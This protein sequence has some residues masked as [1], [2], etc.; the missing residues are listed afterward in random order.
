MGFR[1]RRR[2]RGDKGGFQGGGGQGQG[3]AFTGEANGLQP[4]DDVGNRK[5]FKPV[6]VPPEDI[7]NRR[8]PDEEDDVPYDDVGNR[9][10]ANPTHEVSGILLDMD[11]KK[12]KRRAKGTQTITER[13]G[14]YIVG[15]VNPLIAGGNRPPPPPP[16]DDGADVHAFE[17]GDRP[18]RGDRGERPERG[19]RPDRGERGERPDRSDRKRRF[20]QVDGHAAQQVSERRAQRFFDFEEDDRFEYSL[21][22]TPEQ[23]RAEAL[24]FVDD[25]VR[26]SGRQAVV[27]ARVIEDGDKPK[28]LVTIDERGPHA[29]LSA[30]RITEGANDPLFVMG[31]AALMSLNYLANKV[32]NRYPDDRIR[33]AVLPAS[34]E[35]LYLESLALHQQKARS[36]PAP[37]LADGVAK[38]GEG[39]AEAVVEAV[40]DGVAAAAVAADEAVAAA[41]PAKKSRRKK[42]DVDA[43]DVA[44]DDVVAAVVAAVAA[45]EADVIA[46]VADVGAVDAPAK[47]APRSAPQPAQPRPAQAT[48]PAM[49]PARPKGGAKGRKKKSEEIIPSPMAY[50]P[51]P[52]PEAAPE[53]PKPGRRRAPLDDMPTRDQGRD[54]P[55]GDGPDRGPPRRP[56]RGPSLVEV[57]RVTKKT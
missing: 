8:D 20:E 6:I 40:V 42:A 31:N 4:G 21:K 29:K 30:E 23:K 11:P 14:R 26:E 55:R 45:V 34:D 1:S 38:V 5:S 48:L 35:P 13:V 25:V 33:L 43:A 36:A 3:Y 27:Q 24:R 12:R 49:E 52:E 28:L 2:H 57:V 41:P 53:A 56:R 39:V 51:E 7:G 47:R 46:A 15:G 37:V 54:D 50:V 16:A 17:R 44:V 9:I 18:E 10:E 32:V 19:E 22:S